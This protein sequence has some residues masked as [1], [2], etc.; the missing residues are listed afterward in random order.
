M[1]IR[2][3]NDPF[4]TP[5]Y[6]RTPAPTPKILAVIAGRDHFFPT[7]STP[8]PPASVKFIAWSKVF[9]NGDES[10]KPFLGNG[11]EFTEYRSSA[12]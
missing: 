12:L 6:G 8:N 11:P 3:G 2:A 1:C 5:L 7:L 4:S 10:Y 9:I